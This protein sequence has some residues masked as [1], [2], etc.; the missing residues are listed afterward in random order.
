MSN[1]YLRTSLY[2]ATQVRELDR[3]VI[4][5]FDISGYELMLR[6][7]RFSLEIL[8][9][10]F[11]HEGF[12]HVICGCG[13]NAGD[14]YVLAKLAIEDDDIYKVVIYNCFNPEKLKGDAKRAYQDLL[15]LEPDVR[16]FYSNGGVSENLEY[17]KEFVEKGVYVMLFLAPD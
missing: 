17:L 3:I 1:L 7:G 6:A 5:E 9:K 4:E 12:V 15:T 16:D 13:N 11:P 8:K 2:S 10:T 14:G